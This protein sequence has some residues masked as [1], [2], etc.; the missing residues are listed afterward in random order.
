MTNNELITRLEDL[1]IRFAHQE[2]TLDELTAA[3]LRQERLVRQQAETIIHLQQKIA[4]FADR[5][6]GLSADEPPPPHY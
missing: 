6:P 5:T 3:M 2:A 4:A 1:E